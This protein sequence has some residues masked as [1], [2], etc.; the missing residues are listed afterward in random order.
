MVA[1]VNTAMNTGTKLEKLPSVSVGDV[2]EF[3]QL[4]C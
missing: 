1:T 3:W 4:W 2:T